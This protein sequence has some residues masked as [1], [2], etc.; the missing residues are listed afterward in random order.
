[1]IDNFSNNKLEITSF[2]NLFKPPLKRF[3]YQ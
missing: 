1:M 2:L 3:I